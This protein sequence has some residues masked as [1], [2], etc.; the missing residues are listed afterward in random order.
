MDDRHL[1]NITK[2]K[3]QNTSWDLGLIIRKYKQILKY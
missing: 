1:S 2:L 3:N